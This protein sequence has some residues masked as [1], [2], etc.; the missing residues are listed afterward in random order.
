M[1]Y[2]LL[3]VCDHCGNK[4]ANG[5]GQTAEGGIICPDCLGKAKNNVPEPPY[6]GYNERIGAPAPTPNEAP[7]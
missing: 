4:F 2:N 3:I 5:T 7:D 1:F 6:R